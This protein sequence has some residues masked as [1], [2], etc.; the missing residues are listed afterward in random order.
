[1]LTCPQCSSTT[2]IVKNGVKKNKTQNFL[3]KNCKRQFIDQ[4]KLKYP[5]CKNKTKSLIVRC[6]SRGSGIRDA[7]YIAGVSTKSVLK[8]LCSLPYKLKPKSQH[9][10]ELQ[11]DELWSY[12]QSKRNKVWI[13][14]LYSKE[15]KEV[16]AYEYGKRNTKT[17]QKLWNKLQELGVKVN[18]VKSDNW[19]AFKHV[20]TNVNHLVSKYFTKAIEG[21][22]C[23]LRTRMRRLFRRTCNFSKKISNHIKA[24]ELAIYNINVLKM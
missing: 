24:L 2:S 8:K 5:A 14:Y 10:E 12:V 17:V 19:K 4:D 11:V 16:V 7:A 9:Y 6:L 13:I 20:F 23:L 3:C 22:N 15:T 21:N 1:M 18:T